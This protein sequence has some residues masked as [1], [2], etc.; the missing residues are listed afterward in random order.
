MPVIQREYR[1]TPCNQAPA[2]SKFPNPIKVG[3]RA[4]GSWLEGNDYLQSGLGTLKCRSWD[5]A[6][7]VFSGYEGGNLQQTIALRLRAC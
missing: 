4:S 1:Y 7:A 3:R 2:P 6:F 5:V